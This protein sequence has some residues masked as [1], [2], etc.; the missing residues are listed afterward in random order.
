[1]K[2][3]IGRK[4]CIQ[5]LGSGRVGRLAGLWDIFSGGVLVEVF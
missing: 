2:R 5:T 3:R 1:M 4:N